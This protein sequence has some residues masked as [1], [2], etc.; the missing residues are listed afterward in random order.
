MSAQ[1]AGSSLL[2][3]LTHLLAAD[4]M[5]LAGLADLGAALVLPLATGMTLTL[6]LLAL[7]AERPSARCAVDVAAAMG[8]Q[9]GS[10]VIQHPAVVPAL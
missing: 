6:A 7:R 3:K 5:R 8:A 10:P 9:Q 1:A 2:A 4:A